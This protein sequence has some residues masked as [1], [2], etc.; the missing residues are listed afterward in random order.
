VLADNHFIEPAH[1][2]HAAHIER[3]TDAIQGGLRPLPGMSDNWR[4]EIADFGSEFQPLAGV[5]E[6]PP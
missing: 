6:Y 5:I 4:L 1:V 2:R 3:G